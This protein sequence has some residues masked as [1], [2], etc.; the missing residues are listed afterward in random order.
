MAMP[1][2]RISSCISRI[3][4]MYAAYHSD[5]SMRKIYFSALSNLYRGSG[6]QFRT[7]AQLLPA[8][9]PSANNSS[10]VP[11]HLESYQVCFCLYFPTAMFVYPMQASI[12]CS[13]SKDEQDCNESI[14]L[15]ASR[16]LDHM[17]S[18]CMPFMHAS[19][20]IE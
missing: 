5:M 13:S 16:N 2:L 17:H 19:L 1:T 7:T 15:L 4:Y 3:Q 6:C 14:H 9:T 18:S 11:Q 8:E 10:C 20:K 12:S